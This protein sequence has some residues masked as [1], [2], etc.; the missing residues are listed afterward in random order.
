MPPGFQPFKTAIRAARHPENGG[1]NCYAFCYTVALFQSN[2]RHKP[3]IVF[4]P[5]KS[6]V[7]P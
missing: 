5:I 1:K 2:Q 7:K 3:R 4:Q 6:R